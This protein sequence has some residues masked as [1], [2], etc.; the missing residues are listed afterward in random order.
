MMSP[1]TTMIL[2]LMTMMGLTSREREALYR[3]SAGV[4]WQSSLCCDY[5]AFGLRSIRPRVISTVTLRYEHARPQLDATDSQ[6]MAAWRDVPLC[7]GAGASAV[8]VGGPI[9]ARGSHC[10]SALCPYNDLLEEVNSLGVLGCHNEVP[11]DIRTKK[12]LKYSLQGWV[13]R[14]TA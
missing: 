1:K 14:S 7:S 3:C 6:F 12:A 4:K 10:S 9:H 8:P 2:G 13:V 11:P 5:L